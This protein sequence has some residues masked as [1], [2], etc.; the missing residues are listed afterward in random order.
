MG[1]LI[2]AVLP[3]LETMKVPSIAKQT[4][5]WANRKYQYCFV[6]GGTPTGY[7]YDIGL[8][9]YD[10]LHYRT[11][12]LLAEDSFAAKNYVLSAAQAFKSKGG[13]IIQE[14]YVPVNN[15]DFG[16]YIANLKKAD[17]FMFFVP[18]N[19]P[20]RL[21]QQYRQFGV[22]IPILSTGDVIGEKYIAQLGD[23]GVG[24]IDETHYTLS[25]DTPENKKFID[26]YQKKYGR[27]PDGHDFLG[28]L[29]MSLALAAL[30]ATGGDTSSEKLCDAL[31]KVKVDSPVGTVTFGPNRYASPTMYII[32]ISKKDSQYYYKVLDVRKNVQL[33]DEATIP[34]LAAP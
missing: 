16:P 8:Y 11:I 4:N 21:I 32:Q 13:Q 3:Y 14:Q 18:G 12:T 31:K 25:I 22:K 5:I 6:P 2:D 29:D 10:T 24:I 15:I 34:G 7:S 1:M 28:Y 20:F 23:D 17:A 30:K 27:M 26:T 19:E 9:A 33:I